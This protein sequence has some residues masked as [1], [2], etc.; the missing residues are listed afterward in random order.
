MMVCA[1][2]DNM[3]KGAYGAA[4]QSM[5]IMIDCDEAKGLAL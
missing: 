1:R 5:N 3:G 2:F 4:I